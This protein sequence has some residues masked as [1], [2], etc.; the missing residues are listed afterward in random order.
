MKATVEYQPMSKIL[1]VDDDE[2]VAAFVKAAM[3][4]EGYTVHAALSAAEGLERIQTDPEGFEL[5]ITDVMMPGTS[6][7]ELAGAAAL[8]DPSLRVLFISGYSQ[9]YLPRNCYFLEKPFTPSQ[10]KS[11]VLSIIASALSY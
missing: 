2:A 6:G 1:V 11:K 4:R 5:L 10:L 8:S 3:E 9:A 7:V